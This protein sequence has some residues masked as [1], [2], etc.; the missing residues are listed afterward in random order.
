MRVGVCTRAH[1]AHVNLCI[2]SHHFLPLSS[3]RQH[4]ELISTP[5]AYMFDE[6]SV[7][8]QLCTLVQLN[9]SVLFLTT[10][11]ITYQS[12]RLHHLG[13][14]QGPT[15]HPVLSLDRRLALG[16]PNYAAQP[17]SA[18]CRGHCCRGCFKGVSKTDRAPALWCKGLYVGRDLGGH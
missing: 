1:T 11:L 2:D 16:Y 18:R 15:N 14:T 13:G 7:Y 5:F 9:C 10:A 4:C 17:P 8:K 3:I 12:P 6:L